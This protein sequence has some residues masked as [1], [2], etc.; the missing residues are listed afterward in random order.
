MH[1]VAAC[2]YMEGT[3]PHVAACLYREGAFPRVQRIYIGRV[4]MGIHYIGM[5]INEAPL[6]GFYLMF[7]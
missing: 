1:H 6:Y 4:V 5:H 2:L 3:F 7:L